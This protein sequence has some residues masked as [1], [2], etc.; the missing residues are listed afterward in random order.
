MKAK[1]INLIFYFN[2]QV[3]N[4]YQMILIQYLEN[5]GYLVFINKNFNVA[6]RDGPSTVTLL[7]VIQPI[8]STH[9]MLVIDINQVQDEVT[10]DMKMDKNQFH[11]TIQKHIKKIESKYEVSIE[12]G[13]F[14]SLPKASVKNKNQIY[15]NYDHETFQS[16]TEKIDLPEQVFETYLLG[17]LGLRL[18]ND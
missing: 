1:S 4:D 13:K 2:G 18:S 8:A 14:S 17:I 3:A 5:K 12:I 6:F 10:K 16:L 7:N 9:G 11:E 15:L